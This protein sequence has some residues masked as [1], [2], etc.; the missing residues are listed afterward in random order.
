[1]GFTW[2]NNDIATPSVTIYDSNFT[3]NKTACRFF[4][5]TKYVL[6]GIDENLDQLAIKP[7]TKEEKEL[8]IFPEEAIHKI[9]V[10]KSYGRISNKQ[11]IANISDKYNL[12]FE[13]QKSYKYDVR[14]DEKQKLL[15]IQL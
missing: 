10:G 5:D 11:F 4:E 12:D 2:V 6:L 8:G 14:Y 9:S 7:I 3:L 1:M 15:I 13:E